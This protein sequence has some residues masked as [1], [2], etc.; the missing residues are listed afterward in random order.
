MSQSL[1]ISIVL[2]FS[3]RL[4]AHPTCTALELDQNA[5]KVAYHQEVDP[6]EGQL[7]F[8]KSSKKLSRYPGVITAVYD[9]AATGDGESC[10]DGLC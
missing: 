2:L 10:R 8:T 7:S 4:L 1:I 9:V 5:Y 3:M 6:P